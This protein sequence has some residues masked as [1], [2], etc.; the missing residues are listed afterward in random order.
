[1]AQN[2][3]KNLAATG[4]IT[5]RNAAKLMAVKI[6]TIGASGSKLEIYG[7]KDG[8]GSPFYTVIGDGTYNVPHDNL[9]LTSGGGLYGKITTGGTYSIIFN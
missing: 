3:I 7:N 1:M 2:A 8:S 6:I 4:I 5:N 9:N